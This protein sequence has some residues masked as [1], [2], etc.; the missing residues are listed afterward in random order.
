MKPQKVA[1][2]SILTH[3]VLAPNEASSPGIELSIIEILV[4]NIP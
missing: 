2:H 4:K 3:H 1:R